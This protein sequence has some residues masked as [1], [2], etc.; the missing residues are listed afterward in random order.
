MARKIHNLIR[1]GLSSELFLLAYIK[2][3]IPRRLASILYNSDDPDTGKIYPAIHSLTLQKYLRVDDGNRMHVRIKTLVRD[4]DDVLQSKKFSLD[5]DEKTI[6]ASILQEKGFISSMAPYALERIKENSKSKK[7]NTDA[8]HI[9]SDTL[10]TLAA[11]YHFGKIFGIDSDKASSKSDQD[12]YKELAG[13]LDEKNISKEF[14]NA[15]QKMKKENPEIFKTI[16]AEKILRQMLDALRLYFYLKSI[17]I[18]DNFYDKIAI[19]A[20]N[21]NI[22]A[23]SRA[24]SG[25]TNIQYKK[26]PE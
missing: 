20:E 24:I 12:M 22:L 25:M 2:P 9:L 3:D 21:S 6:L 19:L 14:N 16:N 13:C 26:P 10:S 18:P 8:L 15:L 4:F 7:H 17:N 5:D 23:M 11:G 1:T